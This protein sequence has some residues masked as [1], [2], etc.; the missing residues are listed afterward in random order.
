MQVLRR[1]L[2]SGL[3]ETRRSLA[4]HFQELLEQKAQQMLNEF[5]GTSREEQMTDWPLTPYMHARLCSS[6][7]WLRLKPVQAL[8]RDLFEQ[9]V[10]RQ[11]MQ[12]VTYISYLVRTPSRI[13]EAEAANGFDIAL[14]P[15]YLRNYA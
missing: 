2:I 12:Q 14:N 5:A 3:C 4:R 7:H 1:L 8:E 10:I 15:H 11:G 9:L 6:D 13:A